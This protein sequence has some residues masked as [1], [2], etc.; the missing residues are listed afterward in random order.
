MK[1]SLYSV[2]VYYGTCLSLLFT[3]LIDK[4]S[5]H[6]VT[7]EADLGGS[8]ILPCSV[9]RYEKDVFWRNENSKSVY[10]II[11]G[12]V[13]FHDQ[14]AAYRDRVYSFPSEF[15]KGNYSIRLHN[16]KHTDPGPYSCH[17]PNSITVYVQLKIKD[18]S[19]RGLHPKFVQTRGGVR[20]H[21]LHFST[22]LLGLGVWLC[23]S[24]YY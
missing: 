1:R 16:V 19:I 15:A 13:D 22:A 24:I 10:D 4:V 2:I 9:G 6:S 14:D 3:C 11:T 21:S 23:C 17:I 8:V 5:M 18:H 20:R 7:V 12:E